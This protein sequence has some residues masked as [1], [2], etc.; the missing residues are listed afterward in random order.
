MDKWRVIVGIL[1]VLGI[2]S[3]KAQQLPL[4]SQYMFNGFLVNPA[5]A[6]ADGYTSVTLT[7]REQWL[8]MK[9]APK[10]HL[11]TFQSRLVK[12]GKMSRNKSVWRRFLK[13][14]RSGRVGFGG[15]IYNDK[16][17]LIDRTG[18]QFTYAYHL[19][20][21]R[22]QLS[23]GLSANIYQYSI[24]RSKLVLENDQDALV[25]NSDLKMYIPD[26]SF[27]M[28]YTSKEYYV[29]FATANL[30]Q[31]SLQL[32]N[33]NSS[34]FRS[35]R[36]YSIT[37]AYNFDVNKKVSVVPSMYLKV[38]NQL[39]PQ[40]DISAKVYFDNSYYGGLSFRTGSAF[41]LLGGLT[42]DKFSLGVAY[43]YNLNGLRKHNYGSFELMAG[44]KFGDNARRYKWINR[45]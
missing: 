23:F 20:M 26:F 9:D 3:A 33:E 5:A 40:I 41:I 6:G 19:K 14:S 27:G 42:V 2:T 38:T 45:Y 10:T 36:Q 35:Y 15:Y 43:D 31:S 32:S 22:D 25:N 8:G 1:L 28:Y 11:I 29:G 24:N 39:V 18:G 13:K 12:N 16:N 17:G 30:L 4:F 44:M 34:Q 37:A 21:R 7:A